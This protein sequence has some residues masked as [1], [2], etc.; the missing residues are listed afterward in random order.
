MEAPKVDLPLD[1]IAIQKLI[2]HRYPFLLIDKVISIEIGR[3]VVAIKN[4]SMSDPILQGH[5]PGQPIYP[6]VLMIEGIAQTAAVLGVSSAND[7]VETILLSSVEEA[8]F[9]RIVDPGTT[10]RYEVTLERRRGGFCWFSGFAYV[11]Q[12]LA[13]SVKLSAVMKFKK[14]AKT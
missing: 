5:F 12:E 8:R 1:V 13:V 2:P 7:D 14:E 9:R 3:S 4:V 6:G 10:L 11:D